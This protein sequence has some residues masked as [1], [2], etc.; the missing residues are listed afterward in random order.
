[1]LIDAIIPA[2]SFFVFDSPMCMYA[3]YT[4]NQTAKQIT[5]GITLDESGHELVFFNGRVADCPL[6]NFTFM[7]WERGDYLCPH[8]FRISRPKNNFGSMLGDISSYAYFCARI[9]R[10]P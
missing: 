1:M 9:Y 5:Y 7:K 2:S 6:G 10:L 8:K 3:N 4:T